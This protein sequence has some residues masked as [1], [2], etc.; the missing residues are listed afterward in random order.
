MYVGLFMRILPTRTPSS[1]GCHACMHARAA[2]GARAADCSQQLASDVP[3]IGS[4]Q[5]LCHEKPIG[6]P[7]RA[8]DDMDDMCAACNTSHGD[9]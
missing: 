8:L 9:R 7:G 2:H 1:S 3:V 6:T 4:L 5:L